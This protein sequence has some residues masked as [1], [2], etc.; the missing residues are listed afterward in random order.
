MGISGRLEAVMT[1]RM[2]L[3]SMFALLLS[4]CAYS[5]QQIQLDPVVTVNSSVTSASPAVALNV[6][7]A[8]GTTKVGSRG[9][10]YA[11]TA[12]ITVGSDVADAIRSKAAAALQ[13][14]GFT[15]DPNADRKLQISLK[16]LT[17]RKTDGMLDQVAVTAK[18]AVKADRGSQHYTSE[19]T[20]ETQQQVVTT[21]GKD[22]NQEILNKALSMV[23]QRLLDDRQ[24]TSFLASDQ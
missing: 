5:P 12:N 10:V 11:T 18:L 15:I 16:Q 23:L 21:P 3:L 19:Y 7:D 24:L 17:Y 1:L 14:L 20:A 6:V 9:G 4:A 8:R 2:F 13:Q 22:A